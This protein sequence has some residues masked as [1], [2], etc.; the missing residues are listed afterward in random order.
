MGN[1]HPSI[2]NKLKNKNQVNN[3]IT[4]FSEFWE[5]E[6]DSE[7]KIERNVVSRNTSSGKIEIEKQL[8]MK[9]L[10]LPFSTSFL[11]NTH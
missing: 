5:L 9:I 7:L 3:S 10:L 4:S 6:I 8:K 1:N 11:F 2:L